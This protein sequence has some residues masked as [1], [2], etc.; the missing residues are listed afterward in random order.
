MK[1]IILLVL[2]LLLSGCTSDIENSGDMPQEE[3]IAEEEMAEKPQTTPEP[4]PFTAL[5]DEGRT[6]VKVAYLK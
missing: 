1:K 5:D 2:V 6:C 3:M 4:E